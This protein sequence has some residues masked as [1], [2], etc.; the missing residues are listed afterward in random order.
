[1]ILRK[2]VRVRDQT[3]SFLRCDEPVAEQTRFDQLLPAKRIFRGSAL[4]GGQSQHASRVRCFA[5]CC[6]LGQTVRCLRWNIDACTMMPTTA[7]AM[8]RIVVPVLGK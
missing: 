1:M 8:R 4:A 7:R 2:V 5:D 3:G 6:F